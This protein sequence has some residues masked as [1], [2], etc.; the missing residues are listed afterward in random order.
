MKVETR[1]LKVNWFINA[2][3]ILLMKKTLT[4]T[5]FS[6]LLLLTGCQRGAYEYARTT[7]DKDS[8]I[9]YNYKLDQNKPTSEYKKYI[10]DN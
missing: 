3:I 6:L 10:T 8:K 1:H 9:Q 2:R 7:E 5:I 4:L